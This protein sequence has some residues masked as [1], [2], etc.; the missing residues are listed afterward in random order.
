[1]C[2][3]QEIYNGCQ[4]NMLRCFSTAQLLATQ[5]CSYCYLLLKLH[6]FAEINFTA[7]DHQYEEGCIAREEGC[8]SEAE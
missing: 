1:M 4:Y 2:L 5:I 7:S 6:N 8:S 3:E